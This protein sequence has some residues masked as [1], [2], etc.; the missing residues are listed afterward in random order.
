MITYGT[1]F[2]H[3]ITIIASKYILKSP[4]VEPEDG[5]LYMDIK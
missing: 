5:E 4:V 3:I 2:K 1:L